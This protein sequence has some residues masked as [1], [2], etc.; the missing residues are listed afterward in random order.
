[1][2]SPVPI[3]RWD[4]AKAGGGHIS[5]A[6][7]AFVSQGTFSFDAAAFGIP[8][9]EAR[10]F[11]P[12]VMIILET[13]YSVF[14]NPRSPA[15]CRASLANLPVG[16]FLGAGGSILSQS[17]GSSDTFLANETSETSSVYS[18]TS[19][20]LSVASGR[21]SYTLGLTGPCLTLDTACSSS[22]VAAH[23]ADSALKLVK[24]PCSAAAGVG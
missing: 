17:G 14:H 21:V 10:G 7:G 12:I 5:A 2:N 3:S 1:M 11:D 4:V 19:R 24:C 23:L 6:Y 15:C 20:A 22:L 16:F 13:S 8:W 18:G 9:V